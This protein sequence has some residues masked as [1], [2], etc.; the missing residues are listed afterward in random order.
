MYKV[1]M[2]DRDH[3]W[4]NWRKALNFLGGKQSSLEVGLLEG[5]TDPKT[6]AKGAI[7]EV[8]ADMGAYEIPARPWMSTT[9]DV[10]AN[11]YL[12]LL[13]DEFVKEM[14][15][16]M[17][18]GDV[19]IKAKLGKRV[20]NDLKIAIAKWSDPPNRPSTVKRKGFNNPLVE[21]GLLKEAPTYRI[22]KPGETSDG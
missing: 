19:R 3:G 20:S 1:K 14:E 7:N 5:I 16:G 12:K 6:I 8:G 13:G 4:A 21:K 11:E 2:K 18:G 22:L 17:P 9:L 10:N 15:K